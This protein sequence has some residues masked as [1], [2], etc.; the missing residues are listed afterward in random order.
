MHVSTVLRRILNLGMNK[1]TQLP[2]G[3]GSFP[4]IEILDLS[5]NNLSEN[6]LPANFFIME[7]LRAL[8]L[9]YGVIGSWT[10]SYNNLSENSLPANF[11]IMETLRALYLRYGLGGSWTCPTTISPRTASLPTSS[12]WRPLG[13]STSSTV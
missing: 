9:R 4:V 12:S 11:F 6:S 7:T 1:L 3:F 8:Y 5:Y 2:R 13:L 10:L